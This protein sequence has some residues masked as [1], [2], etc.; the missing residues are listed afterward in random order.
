MNLFTPSKWLFRFFLLF[1]LLVLTP[2]LFK[3]YWVFLVFFRAFKVEVFIEIQLSLFF[4]RANWLVSVFSL[5]LLLLAFIPIFFKLSALLFLSL[6]QLFYLPL[7]L[8]LPLFLDLPFSLSYPLFLFIF[9]LSLSLSLSLLFLF[10]FLEFLVSAAMNLSLS[11]SLIFF[12]TMLACIQTFMLFSSY[13][14]SEFLFL[15][16]LF[17]FLFSLAT[18]FIFACQPLPLS[19]VLGRILMAFG[20]IITGVQTY[21]FQTLFK[22][23]NDSKHLNNVLFTVFVPF[24]EIAKSLEIIV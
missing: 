24:I 21:F 14:V 2:R 20:H 1:T 8:S 19:Q 16:F 12:I 22:P 6:F 7:L 11:S 5:F 18:L 13:L 4:E 17:E 9:S 15:F 10:L 23:L 3:Y